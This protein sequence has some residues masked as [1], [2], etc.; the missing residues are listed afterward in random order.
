MS[1]LDEIKT[2]ALEY[3]ENGEIDEANDFLLK[4][5]ESVDKRL[6]RDAFILKSNRNSIMKFKEDGLITKE[7]FFV[8]YNRLRIGMMSLV[9]NLD[10]PPMP[11]IKSVESKLKIPQLNL[12]VLMLIS[13]VFILIGIGIIIYL[14][15]TKF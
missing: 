4:S 9:A 1:K 6:Y 5:L 14:L 2:K 8:Q 13:Q 12:S 10:A 7:E 3:I 11:V 15:I